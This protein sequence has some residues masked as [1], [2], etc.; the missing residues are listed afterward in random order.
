MAIVLTITARLQ[1]VSVVSL[2]FKSLTI[3]TRDIEMPFTVVYVMLAV[4][5]CESQIS[6]LLG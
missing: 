1:T 3:T 6:S 5:V 4:A 2:K